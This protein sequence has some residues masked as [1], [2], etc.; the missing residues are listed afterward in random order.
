MTCRIEY[1]RRRHEERRGAARRTLLRYARGNE[2][3]AL[4]LAISPSLDTL[5]TQRVNVSVVKDSSEI[6]CDLRPCKIRVSN[7]LR[8][9]LC[10]SARRGYIDGYDYSPSKPY[11]TGFS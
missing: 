5:K 1:A 4:I 7:P 9:V 8:V 10:V 3:D 11:V 6:Q 2:I